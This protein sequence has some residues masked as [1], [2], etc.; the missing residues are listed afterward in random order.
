MAAGYECP[1]YFHAAV[2]C[3]VVFVFV[4]VGFQGLVVVVVV[5]VVDSAMIRA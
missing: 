5:V 1:A 4:V 2:L 3:V